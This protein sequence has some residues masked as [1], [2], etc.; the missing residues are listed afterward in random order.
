MNNGLMLRKVGLSLGLGLALAATLAGTSA[1]RS[2][3]LRDETVR[4]NFAFESFWAVS[5]SVG[6]SCSW[7]PML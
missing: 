1:C 2:R 7:M 6:I 4:V 5:P 3:H